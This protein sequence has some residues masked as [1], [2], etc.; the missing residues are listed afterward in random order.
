MKRLF[1]V[2]L[3]ALVCSAP[4]FG[5][6]AP[7]KATP[8]QAEGVADQIKALEQEWAK[9]EMNHD[10]AWVERHLAP[11]FYAI[12]PV[13][14]KMRTRAEYLEGAKAFKADAYTVTD[15]EVR[16]FGDTAVVT[17]VNNLVKQQLV[18]GGEFTGKTRWTDVW[19]KRNNG[20]W[21]CVAAQGTVVK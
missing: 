14:G 17:G 21:Q 13:N 8:A 1:I 11:E 6:A 3:L 19:V 18:I 10:L 7:K 20:Q 15:L 5:Q 9:A 2:V 4:V 16:V 12:S